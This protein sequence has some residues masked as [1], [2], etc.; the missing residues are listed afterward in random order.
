MGKTV[1]KEVDRSKEKAA[2]WRRERPGG[3]EHANLIV[4]AAD[5]PDDSLIPRY[6]SEQKR[7]RAKRR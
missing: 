6:Q 7:P 1:G 2:S 4:A 3:T 5:E